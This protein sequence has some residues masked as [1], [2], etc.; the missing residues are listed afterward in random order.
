MIYEKDLEDLI[1]NEEEEE[2]NQNYQ[3]GTDMQENIS[4]SLKMPHE[5]YDFAEM[6]ASDPEQNQAYDPAAEYAN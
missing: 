6:E 5:H 4:Q 3:T 1:V 2:E